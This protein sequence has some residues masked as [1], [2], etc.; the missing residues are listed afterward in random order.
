MSWGMGNSRSLIKAGLTNF[1][2]DY[3]DLVET[4]KYNVRAY[5]TSNSC[6]GRGKWAAK[7]VTRDAVDCP[8]CGHALFFKKEKF[9]L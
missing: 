7:S 2:V 5:C 8:S 1:D 3:L 6:A 4:P 9:V